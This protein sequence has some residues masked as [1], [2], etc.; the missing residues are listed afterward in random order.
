MKKQFYFLSILVFSCFHLLAQPVINNMEKNPV[1]M[2]AQFLNCKTTTAI[3]TLAGNSGSNQIWNLTSLTSSTGTSNDTFYE[4]TENVTPNYSAFTTATRIDSFTSNNIASEGVKV[5]L[6][7]TGSTS[8]LYQ[9]F[10][11]SHTSY[12]SP[13]IG[14]KIGVQALHFNDVFMD[15]IIGNYSGPSASQTIHAIYTFDADAWGTLVLP[16]PDTFHNVMRVHVG[17]LDTN[18]DGTGTHPST[19][20]D[21]L[22]YDD[23]HSA[24]LCKLRSQVNSVGS[25][26]TYYY[27]ISQT[28]TVSVNNINQEQ[29]DFAAYFG[30]N[31]LTLN[32]DFK[33]N[34]SYSLA[35]FN[36]AGQN[37]YSNTFS[38]GDKNIM[39]DIDRW[40]STGI[41][42]IILRNNNDHTYGVVRAFK[43]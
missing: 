21:Y 37:V 24:P 14:L 38:T 12:S 40:L 26:N 33:N 8:I 17:V 13:V 6:Q 42:M 19:E 39:L 31:T 34:N 43:Q 36:M 32:H 2:V 28:P 25:V 27:L 7:A 20:T 35:V 11:T 1:G 18:I 16:G 3:S 9:N 23:H 22:W 10:P 30:L 15:T 4:Y 5:I 41:Y 29:I